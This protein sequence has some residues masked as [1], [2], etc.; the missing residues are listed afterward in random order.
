MEGVAVV[1][2]EQRFQKS[3]ETTNMGKFLQLIKILNNL[4]VSIGQV[5]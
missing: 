5:G 1:E 4:F 3:R 2:S